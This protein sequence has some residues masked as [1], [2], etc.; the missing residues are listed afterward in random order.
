MGAR[1]KP[2]LM[3]ILLSSVLFC[4]CV[5]D[6]ATRGQNGDQAVIVGA[7]RTEKVIRADVQTGH[8]PL[9]EAETYKKTILVP[10]AIYEKGKWIS[11][12]DYDQV[13]AKQEGNEAFWNTILGQHFFGLSQPG[14]R[15]APT[16]RVLYW[17]NA[18]T[19]LQGAEGV[20]RPSKDVPRAASVLVSNRRHLTARPRSEQPSDRARDAIREEAV[21]LA[22]GVIAKAEGGPIPH[23]VYEPPPSL[24]PQTRS[25]PMVE[26]EFLALGKEGMGLFINVTCHYEQQGD[27]K[28]SRPKHTW[29]LPWWIKYQAIFR[30]TKERELVP[31][32]QNL[33]YGWSYVL[34]RDTFG[35]CGYCDIDRDGSNELIMTEG[36]GEGWKFAVFKRKGD[37]YI[38]VAE[39]ASQEL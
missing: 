3:A 10:I 35:L 20:L 31:L 6:Q 15:F 24:L 17:G 26:S 32:W 14:I 25:A 34:S 1:A 28:L 37:S 36:T 13:Y 38:T 4:G 22:L 12:G 23:F 8:V 16:K 29:E 18:D 2:L 11:A 33:V 9:N 30:F 7:L 19:L 5:R 39:A 21:S 27:E